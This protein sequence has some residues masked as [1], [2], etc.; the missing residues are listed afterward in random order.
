MRTSILLLSLALSFCLALDASSQ[1]SDT[2]FIDLANAGYN[3]QK[4]D[5]T[6]TNFILINK[7][8]SNF[9]RV[10]WRKVKKASPMFKIDAVTGGGPASPGK[11]CEDT[12]IRALIRK[13]N[14]VPTEA[15]VKQLVDS[16]TKL[17]KNM[18]DGICKEKL[19]E[20]ISF[21][22]QPL[23]FP[24]QGQLS[25]NEQVILTVVRSGEDDLT[26]DIR[27]Y[28]FDTPERDRWLIHYGL[29]YAPSA[30][31][32]FSK[33]YALADTSATNKYTIKKENKNGPKPW[34]NISATINFTYPF[35][36]DSRDFDG[37][38]TGGFGLSTGFEVSG[39]AGLSMIIGQNIILSSGVVI[40]QKHK[41]NGEYKEGDIVKTNLNFEA[42]HTKVWVPELFFTIGFRFGSNPFAVKKTNSEA[43]KEE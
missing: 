9:Y 19:M 2:V 26:I 39:H 4:I 25:F 3:G 41:L 14:N 34:D 36:G 35:H 28:V 32:R 30:I 29:A 37:G 12:T 24:F 27:T 7:L 1:G 6:A 42:L 43:K 40:M 21:T 31:S 11:T 8:K 22:Q 38:F 15:K 18:P 23:T 10:S 17:L 13:F 20:E 33:Y 16:T 5:L